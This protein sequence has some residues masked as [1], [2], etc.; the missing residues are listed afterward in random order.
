M[1]RNRR[2]IAL[3]YVV[4][5]LQGMVFYSP[6]AT[7]YRRSAGVSLLQIGIIESIS[8][9]AMLLLEIPW[10]YLADRLGHRRTLVVCAWLYVLSKLVFWRATSFS[11]FLAERLVM[12]TA[13]AGLSG[14]DA[15]YL[16]ACCRAEEHRRVYARWEGLQTAGL[17]LAALCWPL[18]GGRY[19]LAGLLTLVS[20]TAAALLALALREPEGARVPPPGMRPSL[21]SALRRTWGLAPL[22]LALC[23]LRESAQMITVFLGQLQFLRAGIPE[24]WFGLL[25]GAV[26]AAGLLGIC[27]HRLSARLGARRAG[28]WLIA[29]GALCCGIAAL[30]RNPVPAATSILAL[31]ACQSFLSPLGTALQNELAGPEGRATQLS[32]NAM[33]MDMGALCLY[34][35]FGGLAEG[36][37]AQ[38][39]LLGCFCCAAAV[40]L[41]LWGFNRAQARWGN[42]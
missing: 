39:L 31:R 15:A 37:V 22:L 24:G 8:L 42:K 10:G 9:A 26:T 4:C 33:L 32:C 30:T 16:F 40:P 28:A 11:G 21:R 2:N 1:D 5:F 7:L 35:A 38:A 17:L 13:F 6:I 19:R 34:P 18:L 29:L 36:G 20:A 25:Q 3:F 12:A 23:L 41:F 27:S 14:C